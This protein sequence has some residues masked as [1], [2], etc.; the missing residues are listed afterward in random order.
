MVFALEYRGGYHIAAAA[1][2]LGEDHC[3]DGTLEAKI[4]ITR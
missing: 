3:T 1:V 4:G 2:A